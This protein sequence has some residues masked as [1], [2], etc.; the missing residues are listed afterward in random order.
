MGSG[1]AFRYDFAAEIHPQQLP[2]ELQQ[3]SPTGLLLLKGR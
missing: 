2:Q 1:I 3:T